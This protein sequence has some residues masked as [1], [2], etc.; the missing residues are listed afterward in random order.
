MIVA[1]IVAWTCI[2]VG[3]V[4]ALCGVKKLVGWLCELAIDALVDWMGS[5]GADLYERPGTGPEGGD[6]A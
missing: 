1:T 2:A 6:R 3:F 4:L 5:E